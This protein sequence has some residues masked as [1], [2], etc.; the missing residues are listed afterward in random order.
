M[1]TAADPGYRTVGYRAEY[2]RKFHCEPPQ[3]KKLGTA[4]RRAQV[5]N[6]GTTRRLTRT[7]TQA[8]KICRNPEHAATVRRPCHN[9]GQQP[10]KQSEG[11]GR[12]MADPILNMA[13]GN[14]A[15]ARSQIDDHDQ[16]DRV[17][18]IESHGLL[19]INRGQRNH[20]LHAGLVKQYA[21][22]KA[23]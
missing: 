4:L 20:R 14:R 6:Q 17:A 19:G 18:G 23:H 2:G 1:I 22:Q 21:H 15:E 3:A 12:L 13:E 9:D 5:A 11:N 10:P 8:G 16:N 7:K